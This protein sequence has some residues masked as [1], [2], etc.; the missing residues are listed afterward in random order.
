MGYIALMAFAIMV[1]G[2]IIYFLFPLSYVAILW[3]QSFQYLL[4]VVMIGSFPTWM[5]DKLNGGGCCSCT[6][7]GNCEGE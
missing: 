3:N 7:C 6:N 2:G 5:R 1:T 4:A